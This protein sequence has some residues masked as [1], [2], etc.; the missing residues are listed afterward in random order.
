MRYIKLLFILI[1]IILSTSCMSEKEV[2]TIIT[3]ANNLNFDY[4]DDIYLYDL[5]KII[6][7]SIIDE[8]RLLDNELGTHAVVINYKDSNKHKKQYTFNYNVRDNINPILN[9]SKN[10]YIVKDSKTNLLSKTLC[11]DNA[12]RNLLCE[13][14]GEYDISTIGTYQIEF[15]ATD[16][17]GNKVTKESTLHVIAPYE[18]HISLK[19]IKQMK[20]K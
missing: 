17:S 6:D 10:I 13:V 2:T 9:V 20:M 11:G 16:S 3:L 8:N 5:I 1:I 7:G 19:I 12:D 18:S 15:S 4:G 14:K